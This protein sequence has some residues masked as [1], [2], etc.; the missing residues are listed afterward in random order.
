MGNHRLAQHEYIA[1]DALSIAD[2]ICYEEMV[3][4]EVWNLLGKGTNLGFDGDGTAFMK[5]EYPNISRWLMKMRKLAKHDEIHAIMVKDF[6]LNHVKN[7]Q[8]AFAKE[9]KRLKPKL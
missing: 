6:I 8:I 4:L 1:G 5:R 7:R 9:M 2:I 3:Q